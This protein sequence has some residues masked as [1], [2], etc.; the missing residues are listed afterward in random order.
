MQRRGRHWLRPAASLL[1]A[2]ALSVM[3]LPG[4]IVA[5]RPDWVAIVLL[6]WSLVSPRRF[7]LVTTFFMGL[8]LD[9]LSGAL[10]GQHALALLTILYLS[11]RFHLR[12]RAFPA[13]QLAAT[14]FGLLFLYE[15]VLFWVDGAVGRTVPLIE[16]W[17]P[18]ISGMLIWVS[19]ALSLERGRRGT[20]E[21]V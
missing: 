15:F 13:S 4:G 7:G 16:R 11:K 6:Y 10:L 14:M 2:L 5:F 19:V 8:A 3:P 18:V 20:P 1:A 12:I 9:A 17:G 21:F